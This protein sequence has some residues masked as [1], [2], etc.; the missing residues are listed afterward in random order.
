MYYGGAPPYT[1]PTMYV[2]VVKCPM[3][4]HQAKWYSADVEA[5]RRAG[6]IVLKDVA[7]EFYSKSRQ[8]ANIAFP[9]GLIGEDG[10]RELRPNMIKTHLET[11]SAKFYRLVKKLRKN[12]LSFV[13]SGFTS[14]GGIESLQ[15]CLTVWGWKDYSVD[16]PGK[17]RF[18]VWS[19]DTSDRKKDEIRKVFNGSANDDASQIQIIIGSP[20]IREG[21]S[22]LRVRQ[23]HVMEGYWNY[24]RLLQ[25]FGRAFRYC[26]HKSLPRNQRDV[27]V[28]IYA[29]V[30]TSA[31]KDTPEYS[32]DLYM[33][34]IA[35]KKKEESAPY[36]EALM[37]VAIDR[38][39][40]YP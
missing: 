3:S 22:L 2:K 32:I 6:N 12:Q 26:S 27:R 4:R 1:Y 17:K 9:N 7:N 21:V 38:G 18:V 14:A 25:I 10:L 19:G 39:L 23:V 36:I 15:K 11:Y 37:N 8:R 5:E 33:L 30:D 40:H 24:S 34:N 31:Q 20:A 29:A 35:E 16:G 28:Y 13:Y